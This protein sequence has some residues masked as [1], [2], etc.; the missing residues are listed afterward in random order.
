MNATD[1]FGPVISTYT[2]KQALQDGELIDLSRQ[3]RAGRIVW[4][5]AIT[6]G[7]YGVLEGEDDQQLTAD[8][9]D[10]LIQLAKRTMAA[11][12]NEVAAGTRLLMMF[13]L[14][15]GDQPLDLHVGPD[16]DLQ[17]CLTVML[18]NED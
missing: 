9:L 13:P 15:G 5:M 11:A 17:P 10:E 2:R 8:R 6:R 12:A 18:V 7:A 3:A 4:G 1:F 16:D 14:P